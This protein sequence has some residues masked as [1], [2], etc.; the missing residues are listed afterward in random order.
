MTKHIQSKNL[1]ILTTSFTVEKPRK[2]RGLDRGRNFGGVDV[3]AVRGGG[4]GLAEQPNG[5]ERLLT[6]EARR[7]GR[8]ISEVLPSTSVAAMTVPVGT[9]AAYIVSE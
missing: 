3:V 8:I 9:P 5:A 6:I 7:N 4:E 1:A 2:P